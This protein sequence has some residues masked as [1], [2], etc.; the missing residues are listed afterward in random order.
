MNDKIKHLRQEYAHATLLEDE[1]EGNPFLQFNKWFDEAL[2][3]DLPEPHAMNIATVASGGRPSSRIVLLRSF[4]ESGFVFFTN[5][6]SKKSE[7][8]EINGF[9]ALNFFWQQIERQVRI[10]GK[11]VRVSSEESDDYF[12]SRPRESQWG[13][14]SAL[15]RFKITESNEA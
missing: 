7:E 2:E 1:L 12:A 14:L 9:A 10:E 15:L 3:A 6:K 11:V 4:D 8:M 13:P 5:Y